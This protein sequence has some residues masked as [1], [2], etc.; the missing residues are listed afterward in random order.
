GT[1][2]QRVA[3]VA[4][5]N[6]SYTDTGLFGGTTYTYRVRAVAE[7]GISR[8]SNEASTTTFPVTVLSLGIAPTVITGGGT[9]QATVTLDGP[10]P[11]GGA[12]VSLSSD[13]PEVAPVPANV[14][15]PE[16]TTSTT[17]PVTTPAV[18]ARASARLL[19]RYGIRYGVG[20]AT[21]DLA[22]VPGVLV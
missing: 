19:A 14:T 10:A 13:H 6:S 3:T 8:Y 12:V 9:A 11:E 4:A 22:V 20:G 15:V 18:T 7:A 21:A 17:F 16:G 1:P 2:F 5:N